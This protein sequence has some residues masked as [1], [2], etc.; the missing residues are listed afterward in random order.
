MDLHVLL[1]PK[2]PFELL[3]EFLL[4]KSWSWPATSSGMSSSSLSSTELWA[5]LGE[6]GLE[7]AEEGTSTSSDDLW[8]ALGECL[9]EG[10]VAGMGGGGG[11]GGSELVRERGARPWA[12]EGVGGMESVE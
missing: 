5:D 8:E 3:C 1:P 9:G 2:D 4:M 12:C 6:D 10:V 7:E 11:G